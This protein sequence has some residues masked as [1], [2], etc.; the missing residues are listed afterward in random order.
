[1]QSTHGEQRGDN[2]EDK[3][4]G[5]GLTSIADVTRRLAAVDSF[6]RRAQPAAISTAASQVRDLKHSRD[7][8]QRL[9]QHTQSLETS[10]HSLS[11]R[12]DEHVA[13]WSTV[14]DKTLG[15]VF[16][17]EE[18]TALGTEVQRELMG[19]DRADAVRA[20]NR[21][22]RAIGLELTAGRDGVCPL[23][24]ST[25]KLYD[26]EHRQSET[27]RAQLARALQPEPSFFKPLAAALAPYATA[28]PSTGEPG[29][30]RASRAPPML[31]TASGRTLDA[32]YPRLLE[33][34]FDDFAH[35]APKVPAAGYNV[36]CVVGTVHA[37]VVRAAMATLASATGLGSRVLEP[38]ELPRGRGRRSTPGAI[39]KSPPA[40]AEPTGPSAD[41]VLAALPPEAHAAG[42]TTPAPAVLSRPSSRRSS[43]R[44]DEPPYITLVL[45]G[46]GRGS[47]GPRARARGPVAP[48]AGGAQQLPA[49][50]PHGSERPKTP[51]GSC[52]GGYAV[53]MQAAP[54]TPK[55]QATVVRGRTVIITCPRD[56]VTGRGADSHAASAEALA[57]VM[58]ECMRAVAAVGGIERC[59]AFRCANASRREHT[60]SQY[61]PICLRKLLW[62]A[63]LSPSEHYLR[64]RD[65]FS[66]HH[67][68]FEPE[69]RWL[70]RRVE[71]LAEGAD[72][73]SPGAARSG[74]RH[75]EPSAA[76]DATIAAA[77]APEADRR[78]SI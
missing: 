31:R 26:R 38:V 78:F 64:Q 17:D 42:G 5:E 33:Q 30:R 43:T 55:I 70:A 9:L 65:V 69:L 62:A 54:T 39:A 14:I 52:S 48:T 74:R 12:W 19:T 32:A 50:Q 53:A 35:T 34:S 7:E 44:G 13:G 58:L 23:E 29:G 36:V 76:K 37:E 72:G 11:G 61:C 41:E 20:R 18:H 75:T 21:L 27:F 71:F 66:R 8:V 46:A 56:A 1:M 77:G 68:K 45:V 67:S 16:P 59:A 15:D 28:A 25:L 51:E 47:P 60:C 4:E 3:P 2:D 6:R 22:L 40:R 10:L 63:P 24:R 73:G 49:P 57:G